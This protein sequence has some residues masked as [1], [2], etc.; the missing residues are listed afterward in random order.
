MSKQQVTLATA[1]HVYRFTVVR[2]TLVIFKLAHCTFSTEVYE[3]LSNTVR[4]LYVISSFCRRVNWA[5]A[6]LECYAALTGIS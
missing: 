1:V 2:L 5:F 3:I 6:L 4:R